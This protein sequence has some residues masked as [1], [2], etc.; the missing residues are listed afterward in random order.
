MARKHARELI[1]LQSTADTGH[2]YVTTKNKKNTP[3][4]LEFMMFDP[5]LRKHVLYKEVKLK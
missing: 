4:K 2:F 5:V 1:K 3:Q